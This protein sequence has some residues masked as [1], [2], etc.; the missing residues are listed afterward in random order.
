MREDADVIRQ[1]K[2]PRF[3]PEAR[4]ERSG[5]D[6]ADNRWSG[7]NLEAQDLQ[8]PERPLRRRRV[9]CYPRREQQPRLLD[10]AAEA[11]AA[12]QE[13]Y[14]AAGFT[15]RDDRRPSDPFALCIKVFTELFV[16]GEHFGEHLDPPKPGKY[17]SCSFLNSVLPTRIT[18]PPRRSFG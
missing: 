13:Q 2:L 16:V 6:R 12:E 8:A 11:A 3:S 4:T 9:R 17:W 1:P 10:R 7:A 5:M 18:R 15:N 14:R